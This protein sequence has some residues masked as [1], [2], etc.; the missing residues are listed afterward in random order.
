MRNPRPK[1]LH[2]VESRSLEVH[3]SE[4][5]SPVTVSHSFC[6]PDKKLVGNSGSAGVEIGAWTE[7]A[8]KLGELFGMKVSETVL[9]PL[10]PNARAAFL[11]TLAGWPV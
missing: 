9:E 6:E 7:T 5:H 3:I 10:D 4:N 2:S 8:Q 1:L 11:R